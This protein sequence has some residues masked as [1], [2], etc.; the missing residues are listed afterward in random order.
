LPAVPAAERSEPGP[1]SGLGCRAPG[2]V[3]VCRSHGELARAD[4]DLARVNS[5]RY[6]WAMADT[7][8]PART[9]SLTTDRTKDG[10]VRHRGR[11]RLADGTRLRIPVPAGM[12]EAR[13]RSYVEAIQEREDAQGL[14][15]AKRRREAGKAPDGGETVDE[16]FARYV[17]TKE[18]CGP[19]HERILVAQWSKWISPIIGKLPM[20]TLTRDALEDVRD[21]VDRGIADGRL[22][23][24]TGAKI[25]AHVTCAMKSAAHSKDRTVR[26]HTVPQGSNGIHAGIWPP[27]R[28]ESKSRPW[29]FP[30]EAERL[31]ACVEVPLEWRCAY[32]IAL[33]TGL[34]PGELRT[35]L[36][37]DVDP[38][39]RTITVSRAWDETARAAKV[40]K[41]KAGR[42]TFRIVD[43]LVPL[44]EALRGAPNAPVAPIVATGAERL[45]TRFRGH[46]RAAGVVRPRLHTDTATEE[47]ADF[48]SL[49][50]SFAT[51][52]A[53]AGLGSSALQR[54]MGHEEPTTT[55]TY[56]KQ[57]ED[58]SADGVGSPFPSLSALVL[59]VTSKKDWDANRATN[60]ENPGFHRGLL[61][62]RVGFEPTTF[63][64]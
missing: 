40:P 47:R 61:V 11:I 10:R 48:R 21:S 46:L 17:P 38:H 62:A 45:A 6:T 29:L 52:C 14:L 64:L 34:R 25:W 22:A 19:S 41:T 31:F 49:R 15:L 55:D 5:P 43:E 51:W 3:L 37:G 50:D 18:R 12:S 4:L 24:K 28:G 58:V 27:T 36:F 30:I 8:G 35:L 44:L 53:L 16:W 23:P 26:V 7:T 33:F 9:G 20:A 56:V 1:P 63:G 13:A 59:E 54:R 2:A 32:A 39:A 42:R 60:E 57:A